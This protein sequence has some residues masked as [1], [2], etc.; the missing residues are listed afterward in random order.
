VLGRYSRASPCRPCS[1][2]SAPCCCSLGCAGC[3]RRSY[4]ARG[5]SHCTTQ[6]ALYAE[7]CEALGG[8]APRQRCDGRGRTGLAAAGL[9]GRFG[10]LL[11]HR[12]IVL[13]GA[14]LRRPVSIVSENILKFAVGVLLR[15]FGTFWVGEGA[16][17]AWPGAELSL[18][19]VRLDFLLAAG[20]RFCLDPTQDARP[21]RI[22]PMSGNRVMGT[23]WLSSVMRSGAIC[24]RWRFRRRD[25][26]LVAGG[27][28]DSAA[29]R[30]VE[31]V[32]G[33]AALRWSCGYPDLRRSTCGAEARV[34][35]PAV[36][37]FAAN[38]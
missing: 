37:D 20:D 18:V 23:R 31:L 13:L 26:G 4:A 17:I 32:A 1:L 12:L 33:A 27:L 15:A 5:S 36:I 21:G 22:G 34:L 7:Q 35:V 3:G 28:A 8:V 16:G 9:V 19:G 6:H 25:P 10:G 30:S 2:P 38:L 14:V 29:P 24:R 11:P